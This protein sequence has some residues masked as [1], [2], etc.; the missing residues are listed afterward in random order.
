VL[1]HRV[2][3]PL[4]VVPLQG[5]H[6]EAVARGTAPALG[7]APAAAATAETLGKRLSRWLRDAAAAH[8]ASPPFTLPGAPLRCCS[9][10]HGRQRCSCWTASQAP[11][12]FPAARKCRG[13]RIRQDPAASPSPDCHVA[14]PVSLYYGQLHLQTQITRRAAV[15]MQGSMQHAHHT[16]M[17]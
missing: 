5:Q 2:R 3:D 7:A 4:P 16:C 8:L 12:K 11:F 9:C 6:A 14:Q 1:L 13:A 15:H 17:F 10:S